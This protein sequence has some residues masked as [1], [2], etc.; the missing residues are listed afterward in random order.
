[1]CENGEDSPSFLGRRTRIVVLG[2]VIVGYRNINQ[3]LA[4]EPI[5]FGASIQKLISVSPRRLYLIKDLI[6]GPEFV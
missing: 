5:L 1:M 6:I 4:E 3:Y 2:G